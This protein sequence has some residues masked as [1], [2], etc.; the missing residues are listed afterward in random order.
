MPVRGKGGLELRGAWLRPDPA[1]RQDVRDGL[2]LRRPKPRLHYIDAFHW[3]PP[4]A[5][6]P[7]AP[8]TFGWIQRPVRNLPPLRP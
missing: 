1:R 3:C 5:P 7:H 6:F 8:K 2:G 4:A